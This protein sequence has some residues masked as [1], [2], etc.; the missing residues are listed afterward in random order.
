MWHCL[1]LKRI[2]TLLLIN[3]KLLKYIWI[4]KRLLIKTKTSKLSEDSALFIMKYWKNCF[5]KNSYRL[6]TILSTSFIHNVFHLYCHKHL[7]SNTHYI[8]KLLTKFLEKIGVIVHIFYF[9]K[10]DLHFSFFTQLLWRKQIVNTICKII[11][12]EKVFLPYWFF[13]ST[14]RQN[15]R[16]RFR[17][18]ESHKN[19]TLFSVESFLS[20]CDKKTDAKI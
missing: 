8:T 6:N 10:M 1:K 20:F 13:S 14:C 19:Y 3:F 7:A 9:L 4:L 2:I 17:L 18:F 16:A 5:L 15:H 12:E 11:M